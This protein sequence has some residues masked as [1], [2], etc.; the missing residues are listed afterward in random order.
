MDNNKVKW[1][2]F[3]Y[4]GVLAEEG[5]VEGLRAIARKAGLNERYLFDVTRETIIASGYLTGKT[6]EKSFWEAFRE[7]TGISAADHEL[8]NE[9]LS[10][11][12]LRPWMMELVSDI[13]N[14]G[15]KTAILSDQVNWLDELDARDGFFSYFDRVYN[16][17]HTGLSKDDAATFEDLYHWLDC[18]PEN[19]VFIDDHLPHIKRAKSKGLNAVHF[20]D[21]QKFVRDINSYIAFS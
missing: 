1:V 17:F 14:Q 15:L 2:V 5:F 19:I 11:F 6:Q 13:R 16:S 4:G 3:D 7:N 18:S 12:V 8:R 9:I 10:R 20:T 21:R